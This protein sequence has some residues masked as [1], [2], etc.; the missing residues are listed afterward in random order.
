MPATYESIAT[1]TLG[2]ATNSITFSSIPQTYTDLILV[3]NGTLNS[4]GNYSLRFNGDT[5]TNYSDTALFGDGTN[6]GS[7]RRSTGTVAYIGIGG[8][9]MVT[10]IANIMNYSNTTTNKTTI[11]RSGD[12]SQRVE[13]R[14]SLWRSTAAIT[15][16]LLFSDAQNMAAGTTATLY[17]VKSA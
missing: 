9:S 15:T 7:N 8:T 14:V 10:T 3:V 13:S 4:T 6:A 1:T 12:A 17:G 16:V 11:A 2:S 5:G